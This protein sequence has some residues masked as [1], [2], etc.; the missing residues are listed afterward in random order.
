[1]GQTYQIQVVSVG[2]QVMNFCYYTYGIDKAYLLARKQYGNQIRAI[3]I[4][5]K[6]EDML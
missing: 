2:G 4:S 3:S 6:R 5:I 1:M